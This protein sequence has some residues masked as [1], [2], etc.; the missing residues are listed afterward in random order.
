MKRTLIAAIFAMA[1]AAPASAYDSYS[2]DYDDYDDSYVAEKPDYKTKK[3]AKK[4][5]K[6]S[7]DPHPSKLKKE[8]QFFEQFTTRN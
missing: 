8:L 4:D 3:N 2:N 1:F 5:I 6:V 7:E